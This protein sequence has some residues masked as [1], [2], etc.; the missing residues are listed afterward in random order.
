SSKILSAVNATKLAETRYGEL[1]RI[2]FYGDPQEIN[3]SKSVW[4][5]SYGRRTTTM[6]ALAESHPQVFAPTVLHKFLEDKFKHI[7]KAIDCKQGGIPCEST[8]PPL[9]TARLLQEHGLRPPR[10]AINNI[11]STNGTELHINSFDTMKPYRSRA[12]F[13]P[14]YRIENRFPTTKSVLDEFGVSIVGDIDVWGVD[15]G[16]VNTAAFCQVAR[17]PQMKSDTTNPTT[18][19]RPGVTAKNLAIKRN[20]LYQP[21]FAHRQKLEEL[22][23]RRIYVSEGQRIEGALWATDDVAPGDDR[24]SLPCIADIQN[25]LPSR[26]HTKS[27]DIDLSTRKFFEAQGLLHGFFSSKRVKRMAW[28]LKKSKRAEIDLAVDAILKECT[29][30]TL[31]CYGNGSFR[32]GINLASPH[33]SYKA[34]FAQK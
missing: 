1:T 24:V 11:F 15:P 4:Q 10:F 25:T 19:L 5:T 16:E 34:I 31:F 22:S 9:P 2:L 26:Q 23:S 30:K 7:A 3:R 17:G 12:T 27:E 20:A 6:A 8:P 32:T 14:I 29:T 21:A 18:I 28:S 33:E 13:V